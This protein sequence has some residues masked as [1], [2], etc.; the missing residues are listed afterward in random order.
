LPA[1]LLPVTNYRLD[2]VVEVEIGVGKVARPSN[3]DYITAM[4][5]A[6]PTS[7]YLAT[8]QITYGVEFNFNKNLLVLPV[9]IAMFAVTN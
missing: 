7:K 4:M 8:F 6:I 2:G 3:W 1:S 5:D 9:S